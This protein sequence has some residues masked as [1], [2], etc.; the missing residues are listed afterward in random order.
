MFRIGRPVGI[1]ERSGL[2][3]LFAQGTLLWQLFLGQIGE[4][5]LPHLQP[6]EAWSIVSPMFASANEA[7]TTT[8]TTTSSFI[9]LAIQNRLEDL[10]TDAKR[11]NGNEP[12]A[13]VRNLMSFYPVISE[14]IM[15]TR[16]INQY[17]SFTMFTSGQHCIYQYL[18]LFHYCSLGVALLSRVG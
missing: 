9:T 17:S 12:L 8:T 4:I 16:G 1:D 2:L 3:F 13:S 6:G 15:C 5:G 7:P 14:A 10:N 18:G 11:I